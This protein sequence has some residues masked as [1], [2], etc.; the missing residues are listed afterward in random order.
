MKCS[1]MLL[2]VTVTAAAL[3]VRLT[4][5]PIAAAQNNRAK[6]VKVYILAGQSNMVGHAKVSLLERQIHAPE[7]KA[8]FAHLHH[9]GQW[10][11]RDDVWIRFGDRKGNLTVGFGARDCIGPELGFGHV[12]GDRYD[13]QVL[14]IKTAWGGKSLA[15]DFRPPSARLSEEQL[16]QIL[17]KAR[18]DARRRNRP[19]PTL[20]DIRTQIGFSYRQMIEEVQ[21]SLANLKEYFP[22]YQGQGYEL[23]GFVWFQGWNDMINPEFTAEYVDNM[24]HFIRDV[25]RDLKAPRLPFV[26]GQMG[27]GGDKPSSNTVQ[28]K[29]AQAAAAAHPEFHGNVALVRT[30]VFW[31][32]RAQEVYD[33]GWQQHL[34]EWNQV[35][36]DR[37]YHY[38]GS[39]RFFNAAGKAFAEALLELEK[40][41]PS[42]STR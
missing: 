21:D 14:I 11:L 18:E 30:D 32:K 34:E 38:L 10:I 1:R 16:Q 36:S 40:Q 7:T 28:L 17:D 4:S 39:V 31:D 5:P 6:P 26:I 35:G 22:Q 20:D 29:E 3:T 19:E 25:R 2:L 13:Q 27:V 33:K 41:G 42:H 37:P 15:R 9:N 12:M 8:E 24:V 23:A